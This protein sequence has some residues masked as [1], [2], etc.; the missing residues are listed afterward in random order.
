M[1]INIPKEPLEIKKQVLELRNRMGPGTE[2]DYNS[3]A[4]WYGNRV[5]QYLWSVWKSELTKKGFTWQKFLRLL[6]YRTDDAFLWVAGRMPWKAFVK[7]VIES[8]EGPLGEMI[9]RH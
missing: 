5:P 8:I 4:V 6:K 9:R 3:L 2:I 1:G 7:K